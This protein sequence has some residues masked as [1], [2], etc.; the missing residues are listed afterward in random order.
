[1]LR[2]ISNQYRWLSTFLKRKIL[3]SNSFKFSI[4]CGLTVEIWYFLYEI[5]EI[6][7]FDPLWPPKRVKTRPLYLVSFFNVFLRPWAFQR[8]FSEVK[9]PSES[10]F[11]PI[12]V[13]KKIHKKCNF[14]HWIFYL[15][16]F[17]KNDEIWWFSKKWKKKIFNR[18]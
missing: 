1:M 10:I 11:K 7:P 17:Q 15:P 8:T 13:L 12:L 4:F 18:L 16:K 14:E 6:H 3:D 2:R 5:D 9:K